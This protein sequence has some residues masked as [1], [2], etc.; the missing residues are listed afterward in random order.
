MTIDW[1]L[2]YFL[3]NFRAHVEKSNSD[4]KK[5]I[6]EIID[7]LIENKI[8]AAASLIKELE[9]IRLQTTL[10]DSNAI[11][12]LG[13]C[14][15]EGLGLEQNVSRAVCLFETGEKLGNPFSLTLL[16]DT[17]EIDYFRNPI[18]TELE[19]D[20]SKA[21][22]YHK[23]AAKKGV[24]YSHEKVVCD[25]N[26]TKIL[27][28][29]VAKGGRI[30]DLYSKLVLFND[31]NSQSAALK[32][33]ERYLLNLAKQENCFLA[34]ALLGIQFSQSVYRNLDKAKNYLEQASKQGIVMADYILFC[35]YHNKNDFRS[36]RKFL[37]QGVER[38]N[39][40]L[41]FVLGEFYEAGD[42]EETYGVTRDL[43]KAAEYY[44]L[45]AKRGNYKAKHCCGR[46]YLFGIV[47][48][49][50]IK[51][52]FELV[53]TAAKSDACPEAW[54]TSGE[55][56]EKGIGTK[57][58]PETAYSHYYYAFQKDEQNAAALYHMGRCQ[59]DAIGVGY[60]VGR[61]LNQIAE[62][63]YRG[64]AD[65]NVLCGKHCLFGFDGMDPT[66]AAGDP[67]NPMRNVF[68]DKQPKSAIGF[69]ERA[70]T[71]EAW[72]YLAQCYQNGLPAEGKHNGVEKDYNKANRN[73]EKIAAMATPTELDSEQRMLGFYY[74]A[75]CYEEGYGTPACPDRALK[76]YQAA[77]REG[78]SEANKRAEEMSCQL[79]PLHQKLT[80]YFEQF[81]I[82]AAKQLSWIVTGYAYTPF[83]EAIEK[84]LVVKLD[85]RAVR[86]PY[87]NVNGVTLDDGSVY[88][89]RT[90]ILK[91][92]SK[93]QA[94]PPSSTAASKTPHS[95]KRLH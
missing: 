47:F 87:P 19:A 48:T 59:I 72:F 42:K 52:G 76:N 1:V 69:F 40:A 70:N 65:A 79:L 63:A 27:A 15:R 88:V 86:L 35:L 57:R 80:G 58:D 36:A 75:Q 71:V 74:L 29:L 45:A 9:K 7:L 32:N 4:N 83:K 77:A 50:D 12:L 95:A 53:C 61:G 90:V 31:A 5:A 37:F 10:Q 55:C 23:M 26:D 41:F 92:K 13:L 3:Q 56:Y 28:E 66:R 62:G 67:I 20:E 17:Y 34:L 43:V 2:K 51:K 21:L 38:N 25:G 81:N 91:K 18:Q 24:L 22:K 93:E 8:G 89:S 46:F 73:F 14:Y 60:N 54:I 39:A 33:A 82:N 44:L 49:K 16:G 94:T 64:M 84:S 30:A 78:H 85:P 6:L 68:I 11:L